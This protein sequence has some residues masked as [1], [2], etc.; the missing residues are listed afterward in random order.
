MRQP[1]G[2]GFTIRDPLSWP[3]VAAIARKGEELGYAA[4]FL[5]ETGVR[6]TLATLAGLAGETEHLLIG[7][8]VIPIG[9][10]PPGGS[11]PA[12]RLPVLAPGEGRQEALAVLRAPS[13]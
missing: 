3:D 5:P 10:L 9:A 12:G 4:V 8:G 2:T 13:P 6:D 1:R 7:T 11:R